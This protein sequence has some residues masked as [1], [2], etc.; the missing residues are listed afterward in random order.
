ME[1]TTTITKI[2]SLNNMTDRP[3]WNYIYS[4]ES[5]NPWQNNDWQRMWDFAK[6]SE[7]DIPLSAR[8]L[9]VGGGTGEKAL[10]F[11]KQ[12]NP[13]KVDLIDVSEE[14]VHI[15]N[16][17]F[18]MSYPNNHLYR[19]H[20]VDISNRISLAKFMEGREFEVIMDSLAMQF[21]TTEELKCALSL[22]RTH[23]IQEKTLLFHQSMSPRFRELSNISPVTSLTDVQFR[24]F[25][26]SGFNLH[27]QDTFYM[28]NGGQESRM[29]ILRAK[30]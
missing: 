30:S 17:K 21:L 28:R 12:F 29:A 11:I 6:K 26:E 15:A 5:K 22:L 20:K 16:S 10:N 1:T 25:G 4:L 23:S 24:L 7:V 14:A 18:N 9:D 3:N 13:V 19:A 27:A 2:H 8:I